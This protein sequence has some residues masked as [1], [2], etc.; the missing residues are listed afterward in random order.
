[1]QIFSKS[2]V[3]NAKT[4]SKA[5]LLSDKLLLK[6]AFFFA[7]EWSSTSVIHDQIRAGSFRQ[8]NLVF[9]TPTRHHFPSHVH[10]P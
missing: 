10:L 1:M 6:C 8:L 2:I 5:K 4:V 9:R 3:L 7:S